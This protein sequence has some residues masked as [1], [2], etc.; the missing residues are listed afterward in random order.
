MKWFTICR[1]H[2]VQTRCFYTFIRWL[3]CLGFPY[4]IFRYICVQTGNALNVLC[5]TKKWFVWWF[6]FHICFPLL[7]LI[8]FLL[9]S[10]SLFCVPKLCKAILFYNIKWRFPFCIIFTLV[11]SDWYRFL[12]K[13]RYTIPVNYHAVD[14]DCCVVILW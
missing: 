13:I 3:S 7:L 12:L 4:I 1:K 6:L 14:L 9:I 11:N 10:C 2:L 5:I 8:R